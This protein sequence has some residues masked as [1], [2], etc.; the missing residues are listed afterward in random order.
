MST[1]LWQSI[2]IIFLI[3][4]VINMAAIFF[5]HFVLISFRNFNS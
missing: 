3:L 4:F 5:L 2:P 1:P